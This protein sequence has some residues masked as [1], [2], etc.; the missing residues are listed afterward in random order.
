[1]GF[2]RATAGTTTRQIRLRRAGI[3]LY[4][5]VGV[6]VTSLATAPDLE[7]GRQA[8]LDGRLRI[9]GKPSQAAVE[10]WRQV[11]T[12]GAPLGTL[13]AR[14]GRPRWDAFASS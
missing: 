14:C 1:M 9:A 7:C 3:R 6:V 2:E 12:A 5:A 10:V 11:K 4:S 13:S 8:T